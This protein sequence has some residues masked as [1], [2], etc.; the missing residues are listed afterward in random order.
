MKENL[1]NKS[2][3]HEGKKTYSF[4]NFVLK[5]KKIPSGAWLK[6]NEQNL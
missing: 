6:S 4:S 2:R 1:K 3:Y 5:K